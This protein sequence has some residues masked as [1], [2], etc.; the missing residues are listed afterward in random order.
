MNVFDFCIDDAELTRH[1]LF[2]VSYGILD[3]YA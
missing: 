1:E 2:I 3:A